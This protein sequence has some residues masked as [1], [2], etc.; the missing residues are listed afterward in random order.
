MRREVAALMQ[1][2]F[3]AVDVKA[4]SIVT[5]AKG[6][7]QPDQLCRTQSLCAVKLAAVGTLRALTASIKPARRNWM[8]MLQARPLLG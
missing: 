5:V 8:F 4:V 1:L 2:E 3:A 7:P 6:V